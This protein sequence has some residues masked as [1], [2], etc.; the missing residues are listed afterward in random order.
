MKKI[1]STLPIL[2]LLFTLYACTKQ[3]VSINIKDLSDNLLQN[4]TFEDELTQITKEKAAQIYNIENSVNEY[5]YVSSGATAE[6]IAVFEFNNTEDAKNAMQCAQQR[7]DKQKADYATYNPK[8]IQKLDNAIIKNTGRYL[9]VCVSQGD[10]AKK[11]IADY[12]N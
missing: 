11:I 6:E 3:E 10:T 7:I 5:V 9:I 12:T 1:K 2:I 8:E 4:V